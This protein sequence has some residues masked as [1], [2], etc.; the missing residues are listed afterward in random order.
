MVKLALCKFYRGDLLITQADDI[1]DIQL[2]YLYIR[3]F[4]RQAHY[5]VNVFFRHAINPLLQPSYFYVL[6]SLLEAFYTNFTKYKRNQTN[7]YYSLR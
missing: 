6:R 4:L 7:I 2:P 5:L 3:H 1:V